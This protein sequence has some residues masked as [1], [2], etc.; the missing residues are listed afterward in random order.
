M[1]NTPMPRKPIIKS[2]YPKTVTIL[3]QEPNTAKL[4][5]EWAAFYLAQNHFKWN[6]IARWVVVYK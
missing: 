6:F 3:Y 2:P 5:K 1:S 4:H